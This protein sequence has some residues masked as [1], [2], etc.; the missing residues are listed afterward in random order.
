VES[1]RDLTQV[2][3]DNDKPSLI[4]LLTSECF[5]WKFLQAYLTELNPGLNLFSVK[6]LYSMNVMS[7]ISVFFEDE[8]NRIYDSK[9]KSSSPVARD[10]EEKLRRKS[11]I[12][13]HLFESN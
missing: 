10:M 2:E 7:F 6:F 1:G 3:E 5:F 9:Q 12:L 8:L 13:Q 11:L 4:S